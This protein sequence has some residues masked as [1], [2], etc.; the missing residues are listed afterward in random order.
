[1]DGEYEYRAFADAFTLC[2]HGSAHQ[3]CQ[4]FADGKP[5]ACA[6][7]LTGG[8]VICLLEFFEDAT[9]RFFADAD[10]AIGH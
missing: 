6:A 7:V 9:E 10:A 8:G 3:F 5:Q 2:P 1:M 4:A